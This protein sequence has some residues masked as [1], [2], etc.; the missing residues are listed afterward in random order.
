MTSL[1]STLDNIYRCRCISSTCVSSVCAVSMPPIAGR[2]QSVDLCV[3]SD[4]ETN[5]P[6]TESGIRVAPPPIH[7][8]VSLSHL[9]FSVPSRRQHL[10]LSISPSVS[11]TWSACATSVHPSSRFLSSYKRFPATFTAQCQLNEPPNDKDWA[12]QRG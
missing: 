1:D 2:W 5:W 10:S 4:H 3:W 12:T 7:R 11:V 6:H 8:S 9:P